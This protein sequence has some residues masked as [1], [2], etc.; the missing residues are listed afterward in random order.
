MVCSI[1]YC[2]FISQTKK[3]PQDSKSRGH[4]NRVSPEAVP[5]E[6]R[7]DSEVVGD[8]VC[9]PV[10]T[11]PVPELVEDPV[12]VAVAVTEDVVGVCHLSTT[13]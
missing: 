6:G 10:D 3:R 9:V 12:D 1:G 11:S 7:L 4:P 8:A 2:H 5:V 13:Y